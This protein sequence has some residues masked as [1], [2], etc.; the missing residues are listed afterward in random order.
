MKDLLFLAARVNEGSVS[1]IEM[2]MYYELRI[3]HLPKIAIFGVDSLFDYWQI[4]CK[5]WAHLFYTF[6]ETKLA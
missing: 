3:F 4:G 2:M 5:D 6:Y 1:S